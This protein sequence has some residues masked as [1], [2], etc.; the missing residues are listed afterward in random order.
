MPALSFLT[1]GSLHAPERLVRP[2]GRWRRVEIPMTI[3]V[4][5]RGPGL[6]LVDTGFGR[7]AAEDPSTFP[8]RVTTAFLGLR[9]GARETAARQLEVMGHAAGDV[10]DIVLTHLHVDHAGGLEDFP[11]ATVHV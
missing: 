2:R 6:V 1:T 8:G 4:L 5:E 3:A 10:R 11:A 9:I 7:R